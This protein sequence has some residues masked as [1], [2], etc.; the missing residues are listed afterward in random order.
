MSKKDKIKHRVRLNG[1]EEFYR[2]GILHR[3]DGPARILPNGIEEWYK[4]GRRH[5]IDGPAWTRKKPLREEWYLNGLL[6]RLN[7]PAVITPDRVFWYINGQ[8]RT[9]EVNKWLK[10]RKYTWPLTIEQVVEFQLT[11]SLVA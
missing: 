4:D 11:V 9:K 2:N 1:V 6:H 5:R 7:G 8:C 10:A 3:D